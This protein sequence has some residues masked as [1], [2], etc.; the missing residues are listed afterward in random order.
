MEQFMFKI[1]KLM[2]II[3]TII[4]FVKINIIVMSGFYQPA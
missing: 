4:I 3:I 2:S 1:Q